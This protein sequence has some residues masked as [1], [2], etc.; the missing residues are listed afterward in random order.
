MFHGKSMR[1]HGKSVGFH[2]KSVRFHG[3]SVRNYGLS[4]R[5]SR[6]FKDRKSGRLSRMFHGYS[7]CEE[8]RLEFRGSGFSWGN[9]L[10]IPEM[11]QGVKN[12]I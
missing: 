9:S 5:L 7:A 11:A 1:F 3:K 10:D 8:F 6:D 2:G 12:L 4:G